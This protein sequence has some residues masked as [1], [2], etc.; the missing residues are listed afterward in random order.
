MNPNEL[1]AHGIIHKFGTEPVQQRFIK[2]SNGMVEYHGIAKRGKAT[3]DSSW[4]VIKLT[5]S[6]TFLTTIQAAPANS[7]WDNYAS[8]DYQ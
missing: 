3:S 4:S 2:H 1:A 6:G 7:I 8:L 5:Y